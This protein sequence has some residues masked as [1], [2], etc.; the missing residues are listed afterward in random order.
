MR[1]ISSLL[2][3]LNTTSKK[4]KYSKF[5]KVK[6]IDNNLIQ[7]KMRGMFKYQITQFLQIKKYSQMSKMKKTFKMNMKKAIKMIQK[8]CQLETVDHQ[9]L[10]IRS[11]MRLLIF[12][13]MKNSLLLREKI[14]L[15]F[16]KWYL[17]QIEKSMRLL[18]NHQF[19]NIHLKTRQITGTRTSF[20]LQSQ[21]EMTKIMEMEWRIMIK[22]N[23]M[24]KKK[25]SMIL[26]KW[27]S[28]LTSNAQNKNYKIEINSFY[29]KTNKKTNKRS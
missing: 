17:K 8:L 5:A 1:G 16:I 22:T 21:M 2:S 6:F 26:K 14:N 13:I 12:L 29:F 25:K 7:M 27:R 20:N 11:T 24:K 4:I 19:I 15:L 23:Q 28:Q 3:T 9:F 10:I 18:L